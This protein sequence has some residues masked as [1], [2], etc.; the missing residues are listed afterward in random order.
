MY[1]KFYGLRAHPFGLGVDVRFLCPTPAIVEA[2]AS[3][4][5]SIVRRSGFVVLTGEVGTGKTTLLR[6]L[7]NYLEGRH[8]PFCFV[9]NPLLSANEL[10]EYILTDLR[11]SG[12]GA[13]KGQRLLHLY[14][15]L[16]NQ[17]RSGGTT[18]LIIDEAHLL[19]DE[20][21]EEV[22]LLTNLETYSQKLLQVVLSGQ[23]ELEE[24]LEKN[25]FRQLK[26]RV[27]A[28][29]VLPPLTREQTESYVLRRL[30]IAGANCRPVFTPAAV[31]AIY[32]F[33]RGVPR[34]INLVC[35]HALIQGY[36][37]GIR[38]IPPTTIVEVA[39]ELGLEGTTVEANS[40]IVE[41]AKPA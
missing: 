21:M 15:Y 1:R 33:S 31:E 17:Y 8:W 26:Q 10:F 28:R 34:V 29:V 20:L 39:A 16:L 27:Y 7:T 37:A 23:P 2:Y 25:R 30:T 32:G 35:D 38:P 3:L 11:I 40:T 18:T 5:Y 22:R 14:E 12:A 6:G 24:R 4:Y 36:V 9:F 13:S 19:S 41:K